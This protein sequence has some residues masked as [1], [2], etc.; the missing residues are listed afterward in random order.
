VIVTFV[1]AGAYRFNFEYPSNGGGSFYAASL[2]SNMPVQFSSAGDGSPNMPKMLNT[3][4]GNT[5]DSNPFKDYYWFEAA[6]GE[7]IAF[8]A[9]LQVPLSPTQLSRCGSSTAGGPNNTQLRVFDA[10]LSHQVAV[11][12]GNSMQFIAPTTG[13]FIIQAD[14]GVNGGMLYAARF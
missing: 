6:Q 10:S 7:T 9:S 2:P 3:F 13:T 4:S 5:L 12:C 11:V 1:N 8:S 14:Y